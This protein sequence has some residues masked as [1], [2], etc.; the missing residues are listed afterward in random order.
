MFQFQNGLIISRQ[1]LKNVYL[2][3]SLLY[4][5]N[6]QKKYH[7]IVDAQSYEKH[8]A[9]TIYN[10]VVIFNMSKNDKRILNYISRSEIKDLVVTDN[11][12][13]EIIYTTAFFTNNFLV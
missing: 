10:K 6:V 9:S 13:K 8:W 1:I 4:W 5:A 2:I 7:C 12:L 3:I 11:L